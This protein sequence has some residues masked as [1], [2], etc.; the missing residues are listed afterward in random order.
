MAGAVSIFPSIACA[1]DVQRPNAAA[2]SGWSA[3]DGPGGLQYFIPPGA[4]NM[5]AYEA[6]FPTQRMNGSIEDTASGIWHAIVGDERVV[7]SKAKAIR[8]AD[9]A[10]AYEV[11]V[12]TVDRRNQAIYRV[13]IVK[14]FGQ[15]VAAGELRFTDVDGFKNIGG[16]AFASLE[17]MSVPPKM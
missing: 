1:T 8:V 13:F 3:H 12:A 5:D 7:D 11:L 14:Q 16:S 17:N 6:V 4:T 2:P 15:R 9:G 10:P